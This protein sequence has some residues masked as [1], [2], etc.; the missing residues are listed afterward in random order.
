MEPDKNN[1][2]LIWRLQVPSKSKPGTFHIVEVYDSGDM[3]CDCMANEFGKVCDHMKK[4]LTYI[5]TLAVKMENKYGERTKD[6]NQNTK[7]GKPVS[8]NR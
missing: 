6:N 2:K 3:R 7:K 5:K 1:P 4:T 8:P